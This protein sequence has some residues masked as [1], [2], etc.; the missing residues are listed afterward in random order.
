MALPAEV[1][2]FF[3]D[4]KLAN[5]GS[6]KNHPVAVDYGKHL[7]LERGQSGRMRKADWT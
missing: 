5:W 6:Y 4:L 2:T 3:T 1:P 7:L